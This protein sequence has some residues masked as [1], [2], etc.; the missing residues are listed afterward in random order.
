MSEAAYPHLLPPVRLLADASDDA[1]IRRIRTDR[2]L[3]Y[4]RAEAA[5][6]ALEDLLSFPKRTRMPNLLLVGPSN[7]GKTMIIEKF[8]RDHA[9]N[10]EERDR[11]TVRVPVLAV[12]MPASPDERRFYAAIVEALGIPDRASE[13]VEAK[14]NMAVRVM[15]ATDV[16]L[17]IIDEVHNLLCGTRDRQRRFLNVLRW[18]GNELQIP[19]VA[20]GTAEAMRAIHSDDQLA[21]RFTPFALPPWKAGVEFVRLIN[22]LEAIMPLREPSRLAEP[23]K[24]QRILTASEGI[25][26]EVVAI[27]TRATVGAIQAGEE[28]IRTERLETL[29][30]ISPSQRR[31]ID[32]R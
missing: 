26:G 14:Q 27:I 28:R 18:L 10:A 6:A 4:A 30:F 2:W 25:L 19:L 32:V 29:D 21:N 13:R 8:R 12:Q 5:L 22:T 20:V 11:E 3:S 24:L 1:R 15:R 17:L 31:R 23:R 9:P 7:N 16:Q